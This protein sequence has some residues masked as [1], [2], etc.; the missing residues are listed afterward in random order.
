MIDISVRVLNSFRIEKMIFWLSK[1]KFYQ[2]AIF[3][4][5]FFSNL[6][7]LNAK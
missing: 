4:R 3:R 1:S 6:T 7:K 2:I 5:Q